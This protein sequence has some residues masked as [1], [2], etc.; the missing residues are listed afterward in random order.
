MRA[1]GARHHRRQRATTPDLTRQFLRVTGLLDPAASLL[2]PG[3]LL[4]V[5][6]GNLRPRHAR[7]AEAV[8]PARSPITEATR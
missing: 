5:L 6:T 2:R 3:T 1:Q 8:T 4:R 7:A